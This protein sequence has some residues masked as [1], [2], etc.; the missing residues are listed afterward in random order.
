MLG[1]NTGKQILTVSHIP[2][3]K[4]KFADKI[5]INKIDGVSQIV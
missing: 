2:A 3:V 5:T 4:D 1:L